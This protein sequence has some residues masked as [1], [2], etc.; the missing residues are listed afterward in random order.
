M[1]SRCRWTRIGG[2]RTGSRVLRC[3]GAQVPVHGYPGA[4]VHRWFKP[5]CVPHRPAYTSSIVGR[6]ASAVRSIGGDRGTGGVLAR[7]ARA[8]SR[9]AIATACRQYPFGLN[10]C[11]AHGRVLRPADNARS[12]RVSLILAGQR[13]TAEGRHCRANMPASLHIGAIGTTSMCRR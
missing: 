13:G 4:L 11:R 6:S 5:T 1:R 9:R 8:L 10:S 3:S 2:T 12:P 7:D